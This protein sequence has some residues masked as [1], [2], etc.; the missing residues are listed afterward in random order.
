MPPDPAAPTRRVAPPNRPRNDVYEPPRAYSG[1]PGY[2]PP[3]QPEAI[4]GRA[5]PAEPAPRER[6]SSSGAPPRRPRT[7]DPRAAPPREPTPKG[8]GRRRRPSL[9]RPRTG[10]RLTKRRVGAIVLV[11]LLVLVIVPVALMF[12][13]DSKLHRVDAL[14]PYAGRPASTPGTTWLIVGTDSR[15]DLSAEQRRDLSTGDSDGART[16]T[17]MLVYKPPSGKTS[18]ISIPRDLYVPIPG[19]GSHK[20]NAAFNF[21]GPTLLVRTV[22]QLSGVHIDHY[23]EIGFGGFDTLVDAVGGVN[24]CIDAPLHDPKAG[25][26]LKPGCQ[27]LNGREALGFVR[28]RAFANADLMRVTNQRK[29]LAALMSKATSPS[30]LLNPFRLFPFVSGTVDTLTVDKGTHIWNLAMLAWWLRSSPQTITT[31]NGGPVDTDD[32]SSLEVD[33]S[34]KQFFDAIRQGRQIPQEFVDG[35]AG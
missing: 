28:T 3:Q 32:G 14:A 25:L 5:R 15:A 29:F 22:E 9:R 1:V 31:P 19:Q 18:I 7:D 20:V 11:I 4:P 10:R 13:Y 34:T 30:V 23:A 6:H 2:A 8:P 33:D 12:Y 27:T 24:M 17:I 21:G 16:D 26:N 35:Q